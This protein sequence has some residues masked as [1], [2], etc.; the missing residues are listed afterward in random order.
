MECARIRLTE[1]V[2]YRMQL[3]QIP[4]A[5]IF[6]VVREGEII[7]ERE[8]KGDIVSLLLGFPGGRALHVAV[9]REGDVCKVTTAYEP[10]PTEWT[11]GFRRRR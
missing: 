4:P 1:H 5:A 7:E 10:N 8:E 9:V 2:L 3:R 6:Q 11:A